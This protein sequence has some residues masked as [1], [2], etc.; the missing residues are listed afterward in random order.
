MCY[1]SEAVTR[2]CH[3]HTPPQTLVILCFKILCAELLPEARSFIIPTTHPWL[4]PICTLVITATY[5]SHG[6][7]PRQDTIKIIQK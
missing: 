6:N 7:H 1:V 3:T 5:Q 2:P 4:K